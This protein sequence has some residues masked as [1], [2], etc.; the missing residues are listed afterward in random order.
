MP[1]TSCGAPIEPFGCSRWTATKLGLDSS[2]LVR[3]LER[4]VCRLACLQARRPL[5]R[6]AA[7]LQWGLPKNCMARPRPI[8]ARGQALRIGSS[9]PSRLSDH[10]TNQIIVLAASQPSYA[11]VAEPQTNGERRSGSIEIA[12]RTQII[13]RSRST[14]TSRHR[15]I[16]RDAVRDFV[17]LY[18]AQSDSGRDQPIGYLR[19]PLKARQIVAF[20]AISIRP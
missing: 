16:R 8:A 11:F 18:N 14:A 5:R 4:R 6:P 15:A 20:S 17:E 1:R 9:A 7:D 2:P 3:A 10:F 13:H 12:D 19:P